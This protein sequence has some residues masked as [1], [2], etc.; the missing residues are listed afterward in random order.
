MCSLYECDSLRLE[1]EHNITKDLQI[2][3]NASNALRDIRKSLR[4]EES[5]QQKIINALL[6]RYKSYLNDERVALRNGA[7]ALPIKSAY[8]S[9]V[10]GIV[11]DESDTGLTLFIEPTEIIA[12]NNKII[13][14]REKE[15]EEVNRIIEEMTSHCLKFI[16]EIEH[17]L[18]A[19]SYLDFLLAKANYAIDENDIPAE[20]VKD[21][22]INLVGARH[23][24]ID[25]NK[26]VKNS[27]IFH[28][29]SS[30]LCA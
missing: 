24:L 16:N 22:I 5:G 27:Y 29:I 15:K 2:S 30:V 17:D 3:D 28:Y 26:V 19:L 25:K 1:I 9:K 7:F 20:I 18:K 23:P 12:S 10:D 6:L 4:T 14:L 8:K 21:R 13:R 11:I